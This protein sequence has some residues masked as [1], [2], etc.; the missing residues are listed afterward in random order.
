KDGR[1]KTFEF[2]KSDPHGTNP[3]APM[4]NAEAELDRFAHPM[5]EVC[6]ILQERL[7]GTM[8]T[9]CFSA[10]EVELTKTMVGE[11]KKVLVKLKDWHQQL[12]QIEEDWSDEWGKYYD[13][14]Y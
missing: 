8:D 6:N 1:F 12:F 3:D 13:G 14:G 10:A 9:V 2:Q 5:A 11:W 4:R 7:D